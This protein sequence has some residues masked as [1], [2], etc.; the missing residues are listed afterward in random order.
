MF[1]PNKEGRDRSRVRVET[2]GNKTGVVLRK[3]ADA[4][5]ESKRQEITLQ[6][7]F[8]ALGPNGRRR[9]RARVR[10]Q[11]ENEK[12]LRTKLQRKERRL[13]SKGIYS[14]ADS[15]CCDL[16]KLSPNVNPSVETCPPRGQSPVGTVPD[17]FVLYM[18]FTE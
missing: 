4:G 12:K 11:D 16:T 2:R 10:P 14:A 3:N 13:K 5:V 18:N 8:G 17:R 6:K 7:W 1:K 15:T 9:S